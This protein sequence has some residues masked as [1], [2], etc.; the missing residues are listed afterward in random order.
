MAGGP[1]SEGGPL[2]PTHPGDAG[3]PQAATAVPSRLHLPRQCMHR[4]SG[5]DSS[6]SIGT[7]TRT[8]GQRGT[9]PKTIA[10]G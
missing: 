5:S 8:K 4:H 1:W 3:P 7:D 10:I 9:R 6:G 2:G